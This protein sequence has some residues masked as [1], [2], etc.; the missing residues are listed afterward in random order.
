MTIGELKNI[1]K[2]VARESYELG[3]DGG[4]RDSENDNDAWY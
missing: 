4:K 3:Y 1:L 2:E